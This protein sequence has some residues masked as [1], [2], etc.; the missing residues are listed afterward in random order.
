MFE[1]AQNFE[2]VAA[3]FSPI[4]LVGGG[5]VCTLL[6]LFLWLG[7]LMLGRVL[8]AVIGAVGGG[9][10]GFF[11]IGRH[12][13]PAVVV[14]GLAA[15]VAV[16]FERI[17][18]T[19]LAPVL[20]MSLAIVILAY[21]YIKNTDSLRQYPEYGAS[22]Q[23]A[24]LSIGESVEIMKTWAVDFGA[25]IRQ[26]CSRIPAYKWAIMAV[27]GV[28]FMSVGFC[29]SRFTSAL[30][31]ATLGTVF[32]F[33]GMILLLLYKAAMPLSGIGNKQS[34]YAAVFLAMTGFGTVEQLLL[35][36]FTRKKPTK[37]NPKDRRNRD[38]SD[39]TAQSWRT[40]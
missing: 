11:L 30:C 26:D 15:A 29:L 32:I 31:F 22:N 38:E 3:R 17:F 19:I 33:A 13:M 16:M 24:V 20:A 8:F 10:C 23:T 28:I 18:V 34:F 25:A 21:P 1:I 9:V 6:G 36:Q 12:I 35:S 5:L 39:K 7:G 4:V 14:A 2:Q 37:I 27:L 40:T